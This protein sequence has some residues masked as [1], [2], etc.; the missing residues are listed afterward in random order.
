MCSFSCLIVSLTMILICAGCGSGLSTWRPACQCFVVYLK[1]DGLRI[2][3]TGS[4]HC[5]SWCLWCIPPLFP[6]TGRLWCSGPSR[7]FPQSNIPKVLIP[8]I[9]THFLTYI[10]FL[11]E[12]SLFISRIF[13]MTYTLPGIPRVIPSAKKGVWNRSQGL[14]GNWQLYQFVC[15]GAVWQSTV[16][17]LWGVW[18]YHKDSLTCRSVNW[19]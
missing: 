14:R 5:V 18:T 17:V 8:V 19:W 13:W 11:N 9:L 4:H 6:L 3:N 1:W 16:P 2:N 12:F 10:A 7:R 15:S